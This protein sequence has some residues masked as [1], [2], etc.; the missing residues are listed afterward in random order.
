MKDDDGRDFFQ[1]AKTS[2]VPLD[3]AWRWEPKE[4]TIESNDNQ[5]IVPGVM[6]TGLRRKGYVDM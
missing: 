2:T 6:K 1:K 3:Q 4:E 5:V